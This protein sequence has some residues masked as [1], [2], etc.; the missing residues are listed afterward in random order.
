M[1]LIDTGAKQIVAVESIPPKSE[2]DL[3]LLPIAIIQ[4]V[5]IYCLMTQKKETEES[6]YSMSSGGICSCESLAVGNAL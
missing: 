3:F 6:N 5:M 2:I 1:Y 4:N